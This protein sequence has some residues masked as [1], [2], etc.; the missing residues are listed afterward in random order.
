MNRYDISLLQSYTGYPAISI[1]C[2]THRNVPE[3][4]QDH[5]ALKNLI[6]EAKERLLVEFPQRQ[7]QEYFDKLDIIAHEIDFTKT[8]DTIA[9][10]VS[11]TISRVFIIPGTVIPGVFIDHTFY[12]KPL[13]RLL[14]RSLRYFV[15]S[16]S[17]KPSRLFAGFGNELVEII[18][19]ETND[20]GVVQDGFPFEDLG[21]NHGE[22]DLAV[23]TGDLDSVYL[24]NHKKTYFRKVDALL[25]K[26]TSKDPLP[27]VLV[28]EKHNL[29][30][31][32]E[33]SN[34][35]QR[36][37]T[38][39]HKDYARQTAHEIALLVWPAVD[40]HF[41]AIQSKKIEEFKKALDSL[42][43]AFGVSAVWRAAHEGRVHELIIEKDYRLPGIVNPE[44]KDNL[45]I[46]DHT[47]EIG[48]TDDL[49][50]TIIEEV[51]ERGGAVTF[52]AHDALKEYEHIAALLRY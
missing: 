23:G 33:V 8:L 45:I 3:K 5:I 50:D 36:I 2:S 43:H 10:F 13:I 47:K 4:L 40:A 1:L 28:G 19:P 14:Q 52:V 24:D 12:I 34:N 16:L 38:T 26:F 48:I 51:I 25:S 30:M 9:I 44:N 37:F 17:D 41:L 29:Q 7:V 18:E 32:S 49:T 31:F 20:L 39:I 35:N 21:P 46:Y 15:L 6:K 27:I 42:K 22:P 11:D